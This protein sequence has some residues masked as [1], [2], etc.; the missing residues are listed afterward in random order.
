M[1]RFYLSKDLS[2][3]INHKKEPTTCI[4][5]AVLIAGFPVDKYI[6]TIISYLIKENLLYSIFYYSTLCN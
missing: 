1:Q 2:S 4:I 3:V 6:A 5:F